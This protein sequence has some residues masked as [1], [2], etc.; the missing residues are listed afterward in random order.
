MLS[1]PPA[2]TMFA[3][4]AAMRSQASIAAFMPEPHILLT[5]VAPTPTDKPA[6]S[7]ACRAGAWPRP[8]ASTQPISASSTASPSSPA[9][10]SAAQIAAAPSA[11]AATSF[12]APRKPPIGVR[13]APMTTIG[14]EAAMLIVLAGKAIGLPARRGGIK[15]GSPGN[16]GAASCL[17]VGRSTGQGSQMDGSA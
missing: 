17:Q 6:A 5:V 8:A 1:M 11:G 10:A 3:E 14:S 9:R 15:A 13:A 16:R 7:A 2:T 4:P 12:N